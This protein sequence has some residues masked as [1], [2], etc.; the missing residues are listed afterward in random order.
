MLGLGPDS[1]PPPPCHLL[2]I[3]G[4][5]APGKSLQDSQPWFGAGLTR[6]QLSWVPCAYQAFMFSLQVSG[7]MVRAINLQ[8]V[9]ICWGAHVPLG[10]W[11]EVR[12]QSY[13]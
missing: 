13:L 9:A 5:T 11:R 2:A 10:T 7:R 6:L 3:L 12:Y 8:P 1:S 4:I